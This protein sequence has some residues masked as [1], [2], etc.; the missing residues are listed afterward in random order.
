MRNEAEKLNLKNGLVI[1]E[2]TY[3]ADINRLGVKVFLGIKGYHQSKNAELASLICDEWLLQTS[4]QRAS[5]DL[6]NRGLINASLVGRHQIVARGT[7]LL[8]LDGAHTANSLKD[9]SQ[10]FK[11]KAGNEFEMK[12]LIFYCGE[13]KPCLELFKSIFGTF[14]PDL[15]LIVPPKNGKQSVKSLIEHC[16]NLKQIAESMIE[17]LVLI[18]EIS[19]ITSIFDSHSRTAFLITG[20][21][22]LVGE[23]LCEIEGIEY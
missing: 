13:D 4:N 12:V 3:R 9:I 18:K 23:I 21:F 15:V 17:C 6:I 5:S 14:I 19:K 11:D 2:N 20:S 8:L 10:W 7:N 1:A 22:Y 16:N